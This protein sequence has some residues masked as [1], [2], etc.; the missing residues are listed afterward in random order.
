MTSA[1]P[2]S[3]RLAMEALRERLEREAARLSGAAVP[4]TELLGGWAKVG[5]R[6]DLLLRATFIELCSE[7]GRDA[8]ASFRRLTTESWELS[9]A[10]AGQLGRALLLL[11][12]EVRPS[13]PRVLAVLAELRREPSVLWRAVATRNALVHERADSTNDAPRRL[14]SDL[15]RWVETLPTDLSPRG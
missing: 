7:S 10:T 13:D 12:R 1:P 3:V 11:E 8:D 4:G 5:T 14:L 6:I 9:K 2:M 15:L